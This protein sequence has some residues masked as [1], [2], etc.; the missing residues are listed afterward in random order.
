[1]ALGE[2]FAR[3]GFP[4]S[5]LDFAPGG[6]K[7]TPGFEPLLPCPV[8]LD[9]AALAAVAQAAARSSGASRTAPHALA[10]DRWL[11]GKPVYDLRVAPEALSQMIGMHGADPD[12]TRTL[13]VQRQSLSGSDHFLIAD[14]LARNGGWMTWTR[15]PAPGA[16][17]QD[18]WTDST[19]IV[20]LELPPPPEACAP[21]GMLLH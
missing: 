9:P 11:N 8:R 21:P 20:E 17:S 10:P 5:L 4:A 3:R 12:D 16:I 1:M 13:L 19:H 2:Y 7:Y 18:V 6:R 15:L 14:G